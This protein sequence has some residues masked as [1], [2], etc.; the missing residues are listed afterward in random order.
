MDTAHRVSAH[1][2]LLSEDE[3]PS[4]ELSQFLSHPVSSTR[5]VHHQSL[6]HLSLK[7]DSKA[8]QVT[9]TQKEERHG[10]VDLQVPSLPGQDSGLN[11]SNAQRNIDIST[12]P[13]GDFSE[14]NQCWLSVQQALLN[15]FQ[16]KRVDNLGQVVQNVR[17]LAKSEVG[18]LIHDYM[19]RLFRRGMMLLRSDV[20]L[21]SE[22]EVS[23]VK[24][25]QPKCDS[26]NSVYVGS[27]YCL[28]WKTF[29]TIFTE[30]RCTRCWPFCSQ[31]KL[32]G[33]STP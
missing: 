7:E 9:D 20:I 14:K 23:A 19:F 26:I 27:R 31:F 11:I 2:L 21:A 6:L 13:H 18:P 1:D 3:K 22:N 4:E 8:K 5:P 15:V 12:L 17:Q 33:E 29:G 24:S 10:S 28:N 25:T 16:R 30:K 32:I